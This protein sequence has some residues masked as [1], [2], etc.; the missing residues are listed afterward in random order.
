MQPS[1]F[2]RMGGESIV[3]P[4]IDIFGR[5][6]LTDHRL[7]PF[8]EGVDTS[9]KEQMSRLAAKLKAFLTMATGGSHNYTGEDMRNIHAPLVAQGLND[10][11]FDAVIELI[12]ETL[13]ELDVPRDLIAEAAE[14]AESSRKDVLSK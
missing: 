12:G 1:L 8:F 4:A 7:H 14:V 6:L 5:K 2:D 3:T 9:N 10:T 11:H 13:S